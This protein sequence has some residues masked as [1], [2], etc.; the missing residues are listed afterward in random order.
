MTYPP[1]SHGFED[2]PEAFKN[3]HKPPEK[4]FCRG[5]WI[6]EREI[7]LTIVGSRKPTR[8]GIE[9]CKKIIKGLRHTKITI[10]SGLAHGIDSIAHQAALEANLRTIAFP[11]SGIQDDVMYP[12]QGR[13]LAKKILESGGSLISQFEPDRPSQ[14]WMFP[15]RNHLMAALSD[16]TLVI[17]SG[18]KS[19]TLITA[20]AALEYGKTIA[21]VPG[22]IDGSLSV[23]TNTLIKNGAELIQSPNDILELLGLEQA[24]SHQQ[25]LA[26]DLASDEQSILNKL[27][28]EPCTFDQL[29]HHTGKNPE[30][31]LTI[32]S[33]LEVQ[34]LVEGI[35]GVF[36]RK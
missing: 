27:G 3:L 25:N 21:A 6:D 2:Y 32:L 5:P 7:H 31:L 29:C 9:C 1:K 13:P 28:T 11:G 12:S 16:I 20:Y 14:P 26:L 10:V 33:N 24:E 34:G 18:E 19:G 15:L 30:N 8:Y 23:G 22:P 17:E 35:G 4:L 36:R